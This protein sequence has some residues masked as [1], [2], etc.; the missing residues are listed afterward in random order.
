MCRAPTGKGGGVGKLQR[1][2]MKLLAV[3]RAKQN[4]FRAFSYTQVLLQIL[5]FCVPYFCVAI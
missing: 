5:A 1:R 3:V 4:L 2:C